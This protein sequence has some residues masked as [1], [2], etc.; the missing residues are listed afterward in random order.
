MG[1][2]D[3]FKDYDGPSVIFNPAPTYTGEWCFPLDNLF[4]NS[5]IIKD[6]EKRI[7]AFGEFYKKTYI[8][9]IMEMFNVPEILKLPTFMVSMP[10]ED[11][12]GRCLRYSKVHFF[13]YLL[14]FLNH[15]IDKYGKSIREFIEY[16]SNLFNSIEK[17]N[18]TLYMAYMEAFK[19][20]AQRL[21]DVLDNE[22]NSK[23]YDV[24]LKDYEQEGLGISFSDYIKILY[25]VSINFQDGLLKLGDFFEKNL[26]YEEMYQ[27]FESETFYLLFA[28]II[29][30]YNIM[31]EQENGT[32]D[33]SHVYMYLYNAGANEVSKNTKRYNPQ[34]KFKTNLGFNS[35]SE[36]KIIPYSRWDFH[37]EYNDLMEKH[38]EVKV[39][40]ISD[41]LQGD[42]EGYKDIELIEDIK[43]LYESCRACVDW[44]ILPQGVGVKRGER[45]NSDNNFKGARKDKTELINEVNMRIDILENSGYMFRPI[46]GLD[47]F[48]GYYA[49]VYPNGKIILE[50]FWENENEQIPAEGC[51][52]YVMNIDNFIEKS[53]MPKIDLVEYMKQCPNSGIKRIFHT[54]INNWH[55]NL[56]KEIVG[57]PYRQ[58]DAINFIQGL[59]N[60][61]KKHE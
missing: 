24:V 51:A 37:K 50:K 7:N 14:D 47:T 26:D 25:K 34:I 53:K 22:V 29:Y 9:P 32:L 2:E 18:D 44:E 31:R 13:Y 12:K 3:Y 4:K 48:A 43:K 20:K 56:Y 58:E 8:N 55:R 28:K 42:L 23:Y 61:A 5:R 16:K 15:E 33:N 46:R 57:Q 45:I 40:K 41:F 21:K 59:S 10:K 60:G 30:E 35:V 6:G 49:F 38:E 1:I 19:T 27:A 11:G 52:T 36:E 17:D 39:E 54:T